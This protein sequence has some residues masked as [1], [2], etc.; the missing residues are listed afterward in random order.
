MDGVRKRD[1]FKIP[2][3]KQLSGRVPTRVSN[4][5][6]PTADKTRLSNEHRSGTPLIAISEG[7]TRRIVSFLNWPSYQSRL[8]LSLEIAGLRNTACD[9]FR[10]Q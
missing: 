2:T 1:R 7:S 5:I 10:P 4:G 6:L 9:L 8:V 3:Q